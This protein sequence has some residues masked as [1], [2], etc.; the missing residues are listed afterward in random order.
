MDTFIPRQRENSQLT[1]AVMRNEKLV[2]EAGVNSGTQKKGTSAVGN[3]Y[4]TTASKD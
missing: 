4:Q 1:V 3:R 2:D